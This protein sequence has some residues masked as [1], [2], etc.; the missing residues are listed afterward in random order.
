MCVT[1]FS[2]LQ[3]II[4]ILIDPIIC[5]CAH[6]RGCVLNYYGVDSSLALDA[7]LHLALL[8]TTFFLMTFLMLCQNKYIEI[9]LGLEIIGK[10][11]EQEMSG[12]TTFSMKRIVFSSFLRLAVGYLF[13]LCLFLVV[14]QESTVLGIFFDVLALEFVENIDDVLFA[15]FKRGEYYISF[16]AFNRLSE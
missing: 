14:V 12:S 8:L 2:F 7:F 9:P 15:L 5:R 4:F 1:G 10:G 6:G 13:L 11:V 16:L 3:Q